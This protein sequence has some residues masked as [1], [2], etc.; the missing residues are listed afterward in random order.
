MNVYRVDVTKTTEA[1]ILADSL[2][3]AKDDAAEMSFS[4]PDFIF[5]EKT[6]VYEWKVPLDGHEPV[7]TGGPDGTWESFET[8]EAMD[9]R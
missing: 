5:D 9:T 8:I 4:E 6:D 3:D 1:Y 2:D 7:W